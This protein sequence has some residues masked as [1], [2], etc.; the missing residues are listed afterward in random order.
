M[1]RHINT[2]GLFACYH[3]AYGAQCVVRVAV[4]KWD[5]G[6]PGNVSMQVY[7]SLAHRSSPLP[8]VQVCSQKNTI[9][10]LKSQRKENRK[11]RPRTKVRTRTGTPTRY[12]SPVNAR[13]EGA[14][15]FSGC[16]PND[17]LL[18]STQHNHL[19]FLSSSHCLR[20]VCSD[21]DTSLPAASSAFEPHRVVTASPP[22][23]LPDKP[24]SSKSP[25]S[26]YR[27]R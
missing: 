20:S 17:M 11:S 4:D 26:E 27:D 22:G 19:R 16:S 9:L 23:P 18:C 24:R 15:K 21:S 6:F 13:K 5:Y 10:A 2:L 8:S 14:G 3:R 25:C 12:S 1:E 7:E